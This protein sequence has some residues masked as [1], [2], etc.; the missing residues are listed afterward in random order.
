MLITKL[1]NLVRKRAKKKA[2]KIIMQE[3]ML[4]LSIRRHPAKGV[5]HGIHD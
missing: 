1:K 4:E 2:S 5:R 3:V